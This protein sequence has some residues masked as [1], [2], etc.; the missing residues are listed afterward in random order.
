M[1]LAKLITISKIACRT[2]TATATATAI[3]RLISKLINHSCHLLILLF[4]VNHSTSDIDCHVIAAIS[5]YAV[6]Y[7]LCA[8][9]E[10]VVS[11]TAVQVHTFYSIEYSIPFIMQI[12]RGRGEKMLE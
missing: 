2:T 7:S 3:A 6:C 8:K 4:N 1:F 9:K 5:V 11:I 10:V 12:E